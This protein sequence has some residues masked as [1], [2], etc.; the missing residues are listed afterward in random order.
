MMKNEALK[1][2]PEKMVRLF[3]DVNGVNFEPEND[4][5]EVPDSEEIHEWGD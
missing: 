2:H 1:E 5:T 4:M 3:E